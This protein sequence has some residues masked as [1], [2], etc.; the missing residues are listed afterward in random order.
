MLVER[1]AQRGELLVERRAAL[2]D[3]AL[4]ALRLEAAPDDLAR[5]LLVAARETDVELL[6]ELGEQR[7]RFALP[8][9][10]RAVLVLERAQRVARCARAL[11]PFRGR[12]A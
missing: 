10:E 11:P 2:G 6:A 8:L 4:E 5:E 7:L 12:R 3:V 1:R 9:A